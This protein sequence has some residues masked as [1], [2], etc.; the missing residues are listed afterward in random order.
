MKEQDEELGKESVESLVCK[1]RAKVKATLREL[2]ENARDSFNMAFSK[3]A[4]RVLETGDQVLRTVNS[5]VSISAERSRV[6]R[7]GV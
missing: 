6:P 4:N 1:T 3:S 7:L 2:K 5:V